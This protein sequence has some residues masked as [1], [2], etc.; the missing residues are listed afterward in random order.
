MAQ[1]QKPTTAWM[2][3]GDPPRKEKRRGE[4]G[5]CKRCGCCC[6]EIYFLNWTPADFRRSYEEWRNSTGR[7][8]DDIYLLYPMLRP[9]E[10]TARGWKYRCIHLERD[11]KGRASCAIWPNRPRVCRGYPWY[12]KPPVPDKTLAPGCGYTCGLEWA[13]REKAKEDAA[14]K[15][16]GGGDGSGE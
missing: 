11:S 3:I 16:T 12:G 7:G 4:W 5:S 8:V 15:D 14:E 1:P 9:V 2:G 6:E 10:K 13:K